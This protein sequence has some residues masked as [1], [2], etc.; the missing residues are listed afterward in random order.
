MPSKILVGAWPLI[1]NNYILLY[2]W[3]DIYD[4]TCGIK[5]DNYYKKKKRGSLTL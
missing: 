3:D 5:R 2:N 1:D 4:C